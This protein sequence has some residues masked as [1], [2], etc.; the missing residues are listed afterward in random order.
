MRKKMN[1]LA[2]ALALF[3]MLGMLAACADDTPAQEAPATEEA[4][5]APPAGGYNIGLAFYNLQNPIW[6]AVVEEAVRYGTEL[7]HNVTFV[8]AG[9][10]AA[11]QIS[12]ME[13]FIQ[14]GMDA[15]IVLAV[16]NEAIEGVAREAMDLGIAV[17]DYSREIYNTHVTL[18]LDPHANAIAIVA[19]A[20]PFIRDRYGDGEFE[21]AHLDIPTVEVGVIQGNAIE[22]E[23]L[24][25]FPN[26]QLVFNGATLTTVEGMNNTEAA[27]QANP[28]LRVIISQS[29]GG[30]VGGN[31]AIKAAVS[32]D[33]YDE[34]LL[35]SI[36][37]TE[38]E[39]INIM[40]GYPQKASISLG[41]GAEHGRVLIDLALRVLA[42]ERFEGPDK[43]VSLPITP[44]TAA[45]AQEVFDLNFG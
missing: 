12:Q 22:A 8:D 40:S 36:D 11:T 24:R 2:I 4:E 21:W 6:A 35:F 29:A 32:P 1:V 30:G 41:G 37:A 38:Q 42:G 44:V 16:D 19:M 27:I 39:L 23:M 15:I 20:E 34:W 33:E 9:D 31:E 43:V 18:N 10:S 3:M 7:G 28:N 26:S 45:N 14:G 13:T 5:G 25:V 17:V